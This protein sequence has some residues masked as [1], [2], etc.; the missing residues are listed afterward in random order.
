M[1]TFS[2]K[3]LSLLALALLLGGCSR[4]EQ[5]RPA[6]LVAPVQGSADFGSLRVYYNALPTS[7]ISDAMASQYGV[8]K[9]PG[10]ALVFVALRRIDGDEESNAEGAVAATAYDLQGARQD[11]GFKPVAIGEYTDHIGVIDVTP[12]DTY[13]FDLTVTVEGRARQLEFQRNF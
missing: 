6:D 8:A 3:Y 5:P 4:G 12:R 7:S 2:M 13:R 11:V 9:D 1:K 10:T